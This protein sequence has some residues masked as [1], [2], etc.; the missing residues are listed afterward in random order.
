MKIQY[1]DNKI[2]GNIQLTDKYQFYIMPV[3]DSNWLNKIVQYIGDTIDNSYQCGHFYKGTNEGWIEME[4]VVIPTKDPVYKYIKINPTSTDLIHSDEVKFWLDR[5]TVAHLH[6]A[7]ELRNFSFTADT[8]Y[9]LLTLP[10]FEDNIDI[11][12]SVELT[13]YG[14]IVSDDITSLIYAFVK[15]EKDTTNFY[16]KMRTDTTISSNSLSVNFNTFWWV[17]A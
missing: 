11:S 10:N 13:W 2:G 3:Y 9:T 15:L 6:I 7:T 16:V 17:G 12:P 1:N 14:Q 4:K 8:E 5:E